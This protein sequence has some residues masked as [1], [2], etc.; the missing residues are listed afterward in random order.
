MDPEI[1]R[2]IAKTIDPGYE[3]SPLKLIA[4]TNQHFKDHLT[5]GGK[6]NDKVGIEITNRLANLVIQDAWLDYEKRGGKNYPPELTEDRVVLVLN[7]ANSLFEEGIMGNPCVRVEMSTKTYDMPMGCYLLY[8]RQALNDIF[9]AARLKLASL[10][11][12]QSGEP[13][14]REKDQSDIEAK[15]TELVILETRSYCLAVVRELTT[16]NGEPQ[17]VVVGTGG[18]P[19][20]IPRPMKEG[21]GCWLVLIGVVAAVLYF[22]T[23]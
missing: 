20:A 15:F 3:R 19:D 1:A 16:R 12:R 2:H 22:A 14:D 23:S 6:F 10:A 8:E 18:M 4:D 17:F 7:V 13:F 5:M 9:N 21:C 11:E